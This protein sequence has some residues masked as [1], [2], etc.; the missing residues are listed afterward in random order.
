MRRTQD[1][2]EELEASQSRDSDEDSSK[3]RLD[4]INGQASNGEVEVARDVA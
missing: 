3:K 1:I 2:E 4:A